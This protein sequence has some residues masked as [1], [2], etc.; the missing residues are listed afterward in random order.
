MFNSLSDSGLHKMKTPRAETAET[1]KTP[2][3]TNNNLTP[4]F[5]YDRSQLD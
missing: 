1:A 2:T 5:L 4:P 3:A